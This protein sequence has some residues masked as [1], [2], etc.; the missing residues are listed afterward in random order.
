MPRSRIFVS[1]PEEGKSRLSKKKFLILVMH[2]ERRDQSKF[3]FA[4]LL[5]LLYRKVRWIVTLRVITLGWFYFFYRLRGYSSFNRATFCS[6]R[7]HIPVLLFLF[8]S[9]CNS[10]FDSDPHPTF[11]HSDSYPF[12]YSDPHP[13]FFYIQ[14][15][16]LILILI[17]IHILFFI[18]IGIDILPVL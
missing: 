3:S 11:I 6:I 12:F 16:S 14:I 13:T 15:H 5:L 18:L 8:I 2:S 17:Y 10:I 9:Y 1:D 7:I 4:R